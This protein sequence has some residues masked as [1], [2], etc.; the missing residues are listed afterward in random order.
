MVVQELTCL[1]INLMQLEGLDPTDDR[2]ILDVLF[3]IF[4]F[5]EKRQ[6]TPVNN[7]VKNFSLYCEIGMM[8]HF[9]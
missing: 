4:E 6:K 3:Q 5:L 8:T 9:A 7:E 1:I 2:H